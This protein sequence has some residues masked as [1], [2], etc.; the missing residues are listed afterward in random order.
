MVYMKIMASQA[1]LQAT[2]SASS[3]SADGGALSDDLCALYSK[4]G[5]LLPVL[6][7]HNVPPILTVSVWHE[8]F[9]VSDA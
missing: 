5:S 7:S 9:N 8:N 1:C 6:G 4:L 3:S 2:R